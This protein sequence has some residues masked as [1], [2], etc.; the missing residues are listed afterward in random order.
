MQTTVANQIFHYAVL[1]RRSLRAC[2]VH[3]RVIEAGQH[4]SF[5]RNIAAVA[6]EPEVR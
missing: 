3:F 4:S 2:E 1:R 5:Q 6:I